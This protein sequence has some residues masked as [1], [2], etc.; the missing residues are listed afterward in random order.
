MQHMACAI[1]RNDSQVLE[2]L[3]ESQKNGLRARV[4]WQGEGAEVVLK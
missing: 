4:V 1:V 2:A 3:K